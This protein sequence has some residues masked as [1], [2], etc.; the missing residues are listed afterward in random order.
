[1]FKGHC[2]PKLIILHAV[3]LKLR[4]GLSY[5]DVEEL[6][7]VRE[8]NVDY[9]TTQRWVFKFTSFIIPNLNIKSSR[10][11]KPDKLATSHCSLCSF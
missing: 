7:S 4:F 3:Y 1:M 11:V 8:V 5:R 6:F 10:T 2:F 9:A